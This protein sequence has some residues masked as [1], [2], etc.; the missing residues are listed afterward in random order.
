MSCFVCVE[1][2]NKST[3]TKIEC[4]YNSTC[5][6]TA[7][8]SCY[9]NYICDAN[10]YA[11]CMGCKKEF[12]RNFIFVN[13]DGKF[14]QNTYK[15]HTENVLF[16][17]E[18]SMLPAT[19]VEA[20]RLIKIKKTK[21]EIELLKQKLYLLEYENGSVSEKTQ[22]VH[23]CA[24]EK[25]NG[26]LSADWKCGLCDLI[27]CK[28]C[29]E[30][31]AENHTCIESNVETV[32]F[33]KN[34]V[35][36][37]PGCGTGIHKIIGCNSMFCTECK[38]SFDWKTGKIDKSPSHN[39]HYI[40]YIRNNKNVPLRNPDDVECGR[41]ID[42][43]FIRQL[44]SNTLAKKCRNIIHLRQ[45]NLP[46]FRSVE[47]N[48]DLRIDFLIGKI[49]SD[50][51]K[52]KLQRRFKSNAKNQELSNIV[53]MF[54]T[55]ITDI[56]YRQVNEVNDTFKQEIDELILYTN[57]CF[58]KSSKIYKNVLYNI[59]ESFELCVKKNTTTRVLIF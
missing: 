19:Q 52:V 58:E 56:L 31:S 6:F 17:R 57:E 4:E 13:F 14:V 21:H 12:T 50:E 11:S 20:E 23:A 34:D 18:K 2:F 5:D 39:P 54:I 37:C 45:V 36:I 38:T 15:K 22:L 16:D 48:Q 26:F 1:T 7:C 53:R 25:C 28:K 10:S 55:C 51:F 24:N 59:N 35:K 33:L 8:R 46:R 9:K 49:N 42:I 30:L 32:K 27:T 44:N 40:E 41:E 43:H 3:R 47:N 29:N